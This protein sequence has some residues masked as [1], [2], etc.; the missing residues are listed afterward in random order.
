[1]EEA[2]KDLNEEAED[3]AE[4][5]TEETDEGTNEMEEENE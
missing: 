2:V 5:E 4:G 1:M 3:I